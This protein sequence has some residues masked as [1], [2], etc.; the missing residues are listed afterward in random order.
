MVDR[1]SFQ[2]FIIIR[3][4]RYAMC[5]LQ[6]I[7]SAQQLTATLT[8]VPKTKY[9]SQHPGVVGALYLLYQHFFC[10]F[11]PPPLPSANIRFFLPPQK[12]SEEGGS[13]LIQKF[14]Q[15]C[16]FLILIF[17]LDY[18][19]KKHTGSNKVHL[20]VKHP[21]QQQQKQKLTFVGMVDGSDSG[22]WV[23]QFHSN[24]LLPVFSHQK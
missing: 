2:R 1:L 10:Y 12:W 11:C 8:L 3:F 18:F 7:H 13:K 24:H 4:E 21:T 15:H 17:S 23:V 16:W 5:N 14:L 9:L 19:C 20:I 22:G 6:N